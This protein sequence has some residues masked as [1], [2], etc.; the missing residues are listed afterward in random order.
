MAKL[1]KFP[2]SCYLDY[3]HIFEVEVWPF[4]SAKKQKTKN[5]KKPEKMKRI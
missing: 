3:T 5:N 2:P 4:S 1:L